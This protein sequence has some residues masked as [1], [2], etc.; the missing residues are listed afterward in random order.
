MSCPDCLK[1]QTVRH[2]SGYHA[3]C[4]GCQVR[5]L[6]NGIRF[7]QSSQ[8]GVITREYRAALELVFGPGWK[9]GH[10]EVV[11]E[12]ERIQAMRDP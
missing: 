11:A 12:R 1:S 4:R 10:T 3:N 6:A 9:A 5:A 2:W 8:V 7:W